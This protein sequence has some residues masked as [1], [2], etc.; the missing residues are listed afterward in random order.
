MPPTNK[1]SAEAWYIMVVA[2]TYMGIGFMVQG[3]LKKSWMVH[4]YNNNLD[5][6]KDWERK[7]LL[8]LQAVVEY[9]KVG[10]VIA[11]LAAEQGLKSHD[12]QR[13]REL[14][15]SIVS[16]SST[17]FVGFGNIAD[18]S[19]CCQTSKFYLRKFDCYRKLCSRKHK[20]N[21]RVNISNST[22]CDNHLPKSQCADQAVPQKPD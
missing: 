14:Y 20:Y 7:G 3:I 8:R 16:S 19:L 6:F 2:F 15:N 12:K 5:I 13:I 21:H 22:N 10:H 17:N 11:R 9:I 4:L 1:S 18:T